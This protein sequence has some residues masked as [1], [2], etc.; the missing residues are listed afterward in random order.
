MTEMQSLGMVA[1]VPEPQKQGI[2]EL[3]QPQQQVILALLYEETVKELELK[4]VMMQTHFQM[5]ADQALEL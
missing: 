4:P 3:G 1:L 5:T 2:A